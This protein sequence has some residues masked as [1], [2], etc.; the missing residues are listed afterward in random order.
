[1]ALLGKW[2]PATNVPAL[3]SS[4]GNTGD[5]YTVSCFG[6]TVLD[7]VVEWY[8]GDQAVFAGGVWTRVSARGL[9][10]A[11]QVV[12]DDAEVELLGEKGPL[13]GNIAIKGGEST[14]A[15]AAGGSVV[16]EAGVAG[17]GGTN[18][19]VTIGDNDTSSINLGAA[20]IPLVNNGVR[21][22]TAGASTAAAG[23]TT[24]D[25]GVLPAA[26]HSVYPTTAADGTKGV[27]ANASDKVTGRLILIGNGVANQILKVYAPSGGTINGGSA[28]A[29]FVS[30]SGK[31]VI[32]YCLSSAGNTW[33]AW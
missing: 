1:M 28:D 20:T 12:V 21:N 31:G 25:A 11:G 33:L 16:I 22:E 5:T 6:T 14:T 10:Q 7:S 15:S 24:T 19:T 26:T 23:S 4:T 17:A 8:R 32:L 29:A 27:R 18:G 9:A 2:N 13:G 3:V 30:V